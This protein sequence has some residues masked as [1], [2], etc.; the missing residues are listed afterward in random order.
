[1]SVSVLALSWRHGG[2]NRSALEGYGENRFGEEGAV[3]VQA[4]VVRSALE[5][6]LIKHWTNSAKYAMFLAGCGRK[7]KV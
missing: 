7:S 6:I 5:I 3:A 1:M 4:P 2:L